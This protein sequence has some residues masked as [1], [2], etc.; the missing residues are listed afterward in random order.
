MDAAKIVPVGK[1]TAAMPMEPD[2]RDQARSF[3][4][5]AISAFTFAASG[6]FGARA[7]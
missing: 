5:S 1:A 3:S 4:S 2:L 7:R 6:A